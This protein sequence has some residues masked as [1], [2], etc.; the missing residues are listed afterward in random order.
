[1][2]QPLRAAPRP[3]GVFCYKEKRASPQPSPKG[4]GEQL[5]RYSGVFEG[6]EWG[7]SSLSPTLSER[8]GRTISEIPHCI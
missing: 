8:R 3:L 7:K 6:T 5:A 1:M 4:E 2:K